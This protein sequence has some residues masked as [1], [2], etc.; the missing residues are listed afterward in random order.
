MHARRFQCLKLYLSVMGHRVAWQVRRRG[1]RGWRHG[2]CRSSAERKIHRQPRTVAMSRWH[3]FLLENAKFPFPQADCTR[4][5]RTTDISQ[6]EAGLISKEWKANRAV[7]DNELVQK[8]CNT[9]KDILGEALL[10]EGAES[11][12]LANFLPRIQVDER[13]HPILK[14]S[15]NPS[16]AHVRIPDL[17]SKPSQVIH[18][19][20]AT[21]PVA[22]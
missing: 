16:E 1:R 11:Y 19:D 9:L 4:S 18:A 22:V 14:W 20:L 2:I 10:P 13:G 7:R 8:L 21:E 3:D 12:L 5:T 17:Y 15:R 6:I